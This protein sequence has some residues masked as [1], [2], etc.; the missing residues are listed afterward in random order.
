MKIRSSKGNGSFNPRIFAT[1]VLGSTGVFMA[2]LSFA[3]TPSSGTLTATSGPLEYAAGP[4]FQPNAF[5]NSIA[6]ECIPIRPTRSRPA[7]SIA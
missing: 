4:F 5:G 7:T 2:V 6:G 3:S 1:F